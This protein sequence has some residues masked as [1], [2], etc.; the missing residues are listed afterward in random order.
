MDVVSLDL[1]PDEAALEWSE[2]KNRGRLCFTE[3]QISCGREGFLR[4]SSRG[5]FWLGSK[6]RNRGLDLL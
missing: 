6:A 3:V 2:G 1:C 4:M 5:R